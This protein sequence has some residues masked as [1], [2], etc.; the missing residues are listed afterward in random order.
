MK[1]LTRLEAIEDLRQA[2]LAMT[3]DEH[4]VCQVAKA[5]GLFCHGF[6]KWKF[7]ELKR[8][9]PQITRSRPRLTPAELEDLANRWQLA[10]QF[11]RDEELSCDV[12]GSETEHRICHGWDTHSDEDLARFCEE[13]TGEKLLVQPDAGAPGASQASV[14]R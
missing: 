5:R 11:V 12:Q 6:A 3:D 10:R 13:L 14:S 9:Y 7:S 4:S 2:L 8:N 1:T